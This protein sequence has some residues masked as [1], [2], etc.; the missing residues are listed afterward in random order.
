[1]G[2]AHAAL[3]LARIPRERRYG[4]VG[5]RAELEPGLLRAIVAPRVEAGRLARRRNPDREALVAALAVLLEPVVRDPRQRRLAVRR[6]DARVEHVAP[7]GR[8]RRADGVERP[9]GAVL[10]E[11]HEP[12]GE[13]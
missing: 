9:G 6:G 13:V 2:H 12:L 8:L 1:L 5:D 4:R 11:L 7:L 3:D 10:D